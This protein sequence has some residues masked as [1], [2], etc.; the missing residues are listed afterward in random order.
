M[1]MIVAGERDGRSCVVD[2]REWQHDPAATDVNS[3]SIIDLELT[4]SSVRPAG[5]SEYRDYGIPVGTARW[6]R[7][8]FPADQVRPLHYTN[9]IDTI[10][11]IDGSLWLVL[12]DGEHELRPGDCAVINAVDHGW[13]IGPDGC[14][15]SNILVG[16]PGK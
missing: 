10:T 1:Q 4:D 12:D 11:V 5:K 2:R 16:I 13:R 7:V 15:T 6:N 14:V 9:T 3:T 8:R